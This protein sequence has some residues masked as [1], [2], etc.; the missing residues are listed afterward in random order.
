M[1]T[2]KRIIQYL[3]IAIVAVLMILEVYVAI[4]KNDSTYIAKAGI[5]FIAIIISVVI[6]I[7]NTDKKEKPKTVIIN[8]HK[9]ELSSLEN[10]DKNKF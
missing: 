5:L 10:E 9:H 1:F 8:G 6:I 4:L 3:S 7:K 2:F